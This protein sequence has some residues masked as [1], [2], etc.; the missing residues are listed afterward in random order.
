MALWA[1]AVGLTAGWG[2]GNRP[3]PADLVLRGGR[4]V[5]LD[6]ARPEGQALAV[7]DG[8]IV[9]AGSDEEIAELV[10]SRTETIELEG[11]LVIPGFIEG[12]GHFTGLGSSLMILDLRQAE[13]FD[14][15]VALVADAAQGAERDAWIVGRG[16]HQEKWVTR[17]ERNVEG[18]P[19]HDS[20][21]EVSPENPVSL[22]HA[23]GHATLVNRRAMDLAGIGSETPDPDG[24]KILRDA[25]GRE[26]G[27]LRETA[28]A[29]VGTAYSAAIA[30]MSSEERA[31][32]VR[33][34][35]ELAGEN[36][37]S[38]GVTSFQDA[39][40]DLA[41][42][43]ALRAAAEAGELGVR[44]WV[45]IREDNE[46]LAEQAAAY[47]VTG[48]GDGHL[49]VGG[50]KVTIDGALGSHGAWLLEPYEDQ[51]DS[52][53]LNTIPMDELR[54]TARI[55]LGHDM[56]LC[57][58]AIGDRGNRE[59]LDV[60]EEAL[61]TLDESGDRR[62]RV[63]HAQHLHPDDIP[64]FAELGVVAAMQA[65]HCTSDGPWVP[66]RLGEKRSREGAYVWRDLLDSGALA[67]RRSARTRW[68]QRGRSSRR[69]SR[70]AWPRANWPTS[71]C[72]P[73]TS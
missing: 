73:K 56:Q 59:T 55:A 23:S 35:I 30:E 41:T 26:T 24:G 7:R 15:I 39:G 11:R 51:P 31:A 33:R 27:V 46:T 60:F 58:H 50:I 45:M 2:C 71:S 68:T 25:F 48:V 69:R 5:T 6:D 52:T 19:V 36:C 10:G 20:L 64:R 13:S 67:R 3:E 12:H 49:T 18:Y 37:L 72:S 32:I 66:S 38:H 4:V 62:W 70:A 9:A 21:S 14:G 42:I 63:E 43:D 61:G 17:P 47:R 54:E 57:V 53:G 16:W 22:R 1:A 44:L 8:R 29:L 28:S 65:V 34:E 40:S